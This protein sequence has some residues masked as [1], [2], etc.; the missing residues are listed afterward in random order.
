MKCYEHPEIDAVIQCRNCSK[1]LC[2]SCAEKFNS[3]LCSICAQQIITEEVAK[4]KACLRELKTTKIKIIASLI[5]AGGC[6]GMGVYAAFERFSRVG[7]GDWWLSADWWFNLI[8]FFGFGGLPWIISSSL[9]SVDTPEKQI[10]KLRGD[11]HT[12]SYGLS[13]ALMG[14]LIGAIFT[15]IFSAICTPFRF[16]MS[17]MNLKNIKGTKLELEKIINE[18]E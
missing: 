5:W 2:K 12:A 13:A 8:V 11:I 10:E 15:F 17:L 14:R 4:A 3:P 6:M 18:F 16:V 1:G 9:H 7:S